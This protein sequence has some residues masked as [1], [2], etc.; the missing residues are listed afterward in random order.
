MGDS[1]FLTV[2]STPIDM[3]GHIGPTLSQQ[4]LAAAG[5]QSVEKVAHDFESVLL[6]KVF[7]EMRKTVP[8]SGLID[9]P[10][11]EQIQ[12]LFWTY[13]AQEVADKGGIGLWKEL[14]RQIQGKAGPAAG[15]HGPTVVNA[16]GVS[17]K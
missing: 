1:D 2:P 15:E 16:Q 9:S 17:G 12:G 4:G 11:N 10:E 14:A 13:L 6:Q 5:S 3:L 8:E 7:D